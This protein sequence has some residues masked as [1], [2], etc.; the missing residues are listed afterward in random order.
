MATL[1]DIQ[2]RGQV[3]DIRQVMN[4]V[5]QLEEQMRYAL[6][7][8]DSGNIENGSIGA[9]QLSSAVLEKMKQEARQQEGA[10]Y[11]SVARVKNDTNQVDSE[12]MKQTGGTFQVRGDGDSF[13]SLGGTSSSPALRLSGTGKIIAREAALRYGQAAGMTITVPD[14]PVQE[15]ETPPEKRFQIVVGPSKPAGHGV[16]WFKTGAEGENGVSCDVFYLK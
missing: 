12:G 7:H 11:R 9:E 6:K 13:L 1:G 16:L 2:V 4:Y 14:D 10:A 8:L 15:G 3:T 5:Y